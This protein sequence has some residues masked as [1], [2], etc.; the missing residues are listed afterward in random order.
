[1]NIDKLINVIPN[2]VIKE[3]PMV[4]SRFGIDTPLRL[5]HFLAQCAHE[6][7][8]FTRTSENLNY[9]SE[10]LLEIFH[11]YFDP[12]KALLYARNP[13]KIANYVYAF[14]EGNGSEESGDGWKHRGFGYIQ[15]TFKNN[16]DAFFKFV[17][18]P[19][20]TDPQIIGSNYPL[21]VSGFWWSN[22]KIN[23][24]ADLGSDSSVVEK[25]TKKVNIGL[26]GL[27]QRISEFNKFYS[28]LK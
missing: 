22:N 3:L 25:V 5:S 13:E 8:N 1:M 19:L 7:E 6:S 27:R 28:L 15:D 12:A 2:S 17:G 14:R 26:V 18:L 20:E 10:G 24:I 23:T 16:H 11:K 21:F 9:S 4:I